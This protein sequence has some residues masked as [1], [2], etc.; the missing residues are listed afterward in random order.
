M[1]TALINKVTREVVRLVD[2]VPSPISESREAIQLT[3]E[4]AATVNKAKTKSEKIF[5]V[6]DTL[7]NL[8]TARATLRQARE[9][10]ETKKRPFQQRL[11]SALSGMSVAERKELL[12]AI[13]PGLVANDKEV[14]LESLSELSAVGRNEAWTTLIVKLNQILNK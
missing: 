7:V 9:A 14:C 5:F 10:A 1:K 13:M 2:V 4:E 6:N 3:N 12:T 11:K 8:N